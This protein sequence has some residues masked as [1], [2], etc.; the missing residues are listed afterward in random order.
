MPPK[1]RVS[2]DSDSGDDTD[3]TVS[4][5]VMVYRPALPLPPSPPADAQQKKKKKKKSTKVEHKPNNKEDTKAGVEAARDVLTYAHQMVARASQ[6]LKDA[7]R[8]HTNELARARRQRKKQQQQKK[9][10]KK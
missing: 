5:D 2:D 7:Q 9:T 3:A 1:R 10:T 6:Q 8:A 4:D